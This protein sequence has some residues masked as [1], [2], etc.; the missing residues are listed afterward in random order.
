VN[1][2]YYEILEVS[3]TAKQSDIKKSFDRLV[4]KNQS[5]LYTGKIVNTV[6]LRELEKAYEVLSDPVKR[7][8]YDSKLKIEQEFGP[9]ES[10][11]NLTQEEGFMEDETEEDS[12]A[13]RKK[14]I[15]NKI[16]VVLAG[17]ILIIIYILLKQD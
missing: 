6:Y 12:S 7:L 2:F 9:I 15:T 1:K 4:E 3:N 10:E 13:I 5:E 17:I 16:I 11:N 8:H 14:I